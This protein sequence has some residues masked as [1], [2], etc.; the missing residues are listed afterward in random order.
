VVKNIIKNVA[1]HAAPYGVVVLRQRIK[2]KEAINY[3]PICE[4]EGAF[5]PMSSTGG[6]RQ[7]AVCPN[8]GSLERHRLMWLF[9]KREVGLNTIKNK[10]M[11]HVAAEAMLEPKFRKI[12]GKNY[13]TADYMER[14]DVKMDI[15][16]IKY[17]DN[18]FDAIICNHVLEHVEDDV[19]A[20]KEMRR[21]LKKNGWAIYLVPIADMP[22]TYEDKKITSKK[23]R[24]EAFGQ[25]DH[26]RKY[27][28]DFID[29]LESAGY[30]IYVYK[31]KDIA[32]RREIKRMS[33]Q[34]DSKL[35]GFISTDIYFMKNK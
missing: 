30:A 17:P 35:W 28:R 19:K 3:C 25:D 9:L 21:V 6:T 34:E 18:R 7:K 15:T 8:C 16:D 31:A 22:T 32:T 20:M 14:A 5:L 27:G 11:L 26:A 33:L 4:Q 23:G 29:R 12:V 13:L 2:N 24:L 1:K 10:T